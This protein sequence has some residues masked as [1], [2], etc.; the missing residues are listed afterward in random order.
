MFLK[1]SFNLRDIPYH[2]K[3]IVLSF[4]SFKDL[5]LLSYCILALKFEK[6]L[7]KNISTFKL[8][9]KSLLCLQTIT[10]INSVIT[11]SLK[12]EHD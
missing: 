12:Y 6:S 4:Y 11:V 1:F 5:N 8:T 7:Q 3:I 9:L 2:L 10:Y